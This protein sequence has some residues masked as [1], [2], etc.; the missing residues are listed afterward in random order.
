MVCKKRC[1][2]HKK[3][4]RSFENTANTPFDGIGQPELLKAN[5]KG[6]WSRRINSEHRIV[7]KVEVNKIIV[8][9]LKG[10]YQ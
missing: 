1:K 2:E 7:Y 3:I 8:F 5:F 9:S 10:H 6:Y 4:I